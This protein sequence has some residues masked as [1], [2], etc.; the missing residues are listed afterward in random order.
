M[1]IVGRVDEREWKAECLRLE[2]KLADIGTSAKDARKKGGYIHAETARI[3][4]AVHIF[5][6]QKLND[7]VKF[8]K[9]A[10]ST[11]FRAIDSD[12]EKIIKGEQRLKSTFQNSAE[13]YSQRNQET[14]DLNNRASNLSNWLRDQSAALEKTEEL[15]LEINKKIKTS[16][17]ESSEENKV[18]LVKGALVAMKKEII[19]MDQKR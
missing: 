15:L 11:M 4:Q 17:L 2:K 7:L 8:V 19:E 9:P 18:S 12:L 1:M 3:S 5:I 16:T 6:F 14:L 10:T 13:S